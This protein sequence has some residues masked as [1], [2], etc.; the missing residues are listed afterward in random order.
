LCQSTAYTR[1]NNRHYFA[2]TKQQDTGEIRT[3]HA[4]TEKEK[5]GGEYLHEEQKNDPEYLEPNIDIVFLSYQC[6]QVSLPTTVRFLRKK[7]TSVA[8]NF[9]SIHRNYFKIS[10]FW[11]ALF[12]YYIFVFVGLKFK[13]SRKTC[14]LPHYNR[15]T[16]A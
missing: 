10:T 15:T 1:N 7:P 11:C 12:K 6:L 16:K 14:K 4:S 13:M 9:R 8:H 5:H 3:A 2:Q